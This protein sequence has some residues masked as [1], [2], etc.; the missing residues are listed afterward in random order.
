MRA[1][2][3]FM[4]AAASCL[5]ACLVGCAD[6]SERQRGTAQG[7]GLGAVA[8]AVLGGVTGNSAGQGAVIGGVVGAVAGNL[9]SKRMEDKQ[10]ALAEASAGTGIQVDRTADNRLKLNV[11]SDVSFDTGRADIKP[12][13]RPVLDE[14]GRNL[15]PNV[16]VTV[17]GHTDATGSDAINEPLSRQRAEAVRDYLAARGLNAQRVSVLGRGSREP[18]ASNDT[19]DGRAANRRV[20]IFLSD[21]AS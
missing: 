12:Q 19:D 10:R 11:P 20:E 8:G 15:D 1:E 13:M 5:I 18:I 21:Q 2:S 9:W 16:R 4:T 6:M 3:A 17:V 14:L 7:A